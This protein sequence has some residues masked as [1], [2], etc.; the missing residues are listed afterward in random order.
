MRTN[1][2]RQ[3]MKRDIRTYRI[4]WRHLTMTT[5]TSSSYERARARKRVE[6]NRRRYFGRRSSNGGGGSC[7][8]SEEEERGE[9][10]ARDCRKDGGKEYRRAS[11]GERRRSSSRDKSKRRK[12]SPSPSRPERK[13][14]RC[15]SDSDSPHSHSRNKTSHFHGHSQCKY[16]SF[17]KRHW[18]RSGG[19]RHNKC[20]CFSYY[21]SERENRVCSK[22]K[23]R[24]SIS[25]VRSEGVRHHHS[26][27]RESVFH[28]SNSKS[29]RTSKVRTQTS[30][31]VNYYLEDAYL[32]ADSDSPRK[33]SYLGNSAL[34]G[35]LLSKE[36]AQM[37]RTTKSWD[38]RCR[39]NPALSL[40]Q[41][42]SDLKE[43]HKSSVGLTDEL[44]DRHG[45]W[46][47]P[48]P[49]AY[50]KKDQLLTPG[51]FATDENDWLDLSLKAPAKP[52]PKIEGISREDLSLCFNSSVMPAPTVA[53]ALKDAE[54]EGHSDVKAMLTSS[55][56]EGFEAS[57]RSTSSFCSVQADVPML[58]MS[59]RR[60]L[61]D[62]DRSGDTT[63]QVDATFSLNNTKIPPPLH[64]DRI[65]NTFV[66]PLESGSRT[67]EERCLD[68]LN[69]LISLSRGDEETVVSVD[70]NN[71]VSGSFTE[72]LAV[73]ASDNHE[74]HTDKI[75]N[76]STG[77]GMCVSVIEI[78]NSTS[79]EQIDVER[80]EPSGYK[81]VNSIDCFTSV[82]EKEEVLVKQ[83]MPAASIEPYPQSQSPSP[84]KS[85]KTSL[86]LPL[87]H[88]VVE[89]SDST[90]NLE[91]DEEREIEVQ[92]Q[93]ASSLPV[94][95]LNEF[96]GS[97]DQCLSP[98]LRDLSPVQ[99]VS[100]HRTSV[101][102]FSNAAAEGTDKDRILDLSDLDHATDLFIEKVHSLFIHGRPHSPSM[103]ASFNHC[104]S[105]KKSICQQPENK[106]K[107]LTDEC[108]VSRPKTL[109]IV[110]LSESSPSSS[111]SSES[112]SDIEVAL[113]TKRA[114]FIPE[115]KFKSLERDGNTHDSA[116]IAHDH[117]IQYLNEDVV[118]CST[119][120]PLR[121]GK[122]SYGGD[123]PS[124]V[125]YIRDK[126]GNLIQVVEVGDSDND[127]D[128][129]EPDTKSCA[130][131]KNDES[132]S[133]H[134]E[135]L[136]VIQEIK[137]MLQ[138][139]AS[140]SDKSSEHD[141]LSGPNSHPVLKVRPSGRIQ[142][143]S[144]EPSQRIRSR[145]LVLEGSES[146]ESD[147]DTEATGRTSAVSSTGGFK[148][149]EKWKRGIVCDLCSGGPSLALGEWYCW[150]CGTPATKCQC[151]EDKKVRKQLSLGYRKGQKQKKRGRQILD[152]Q[153]SGKVHRMCA[154]WSSE[155]YVK[156][157]PK[158]EPHFAQLDT[159]V[160]RGNTLVCKHPDCK[161]TGA[162]LGCRVRACRRSFH[163]P[164]AE[165]LANQCMVRMWD[166]ALVPVACQYHRHIEEQAERAK[167]KSL[168][169]KITDP[170]REGKM[171]VA[172]E[173]PYIGVKLLCEDIAEGQEQVQIPC[174]NDVDDDPAPIIR[175]ITKCW[176]KGR[177]VDHL[178]PVGTELA[179]GCYGC[180]GPN[181]DNPHSLMPPHVMGAD[182]A[183]RSRESDN[184]LDW[185]GERMYGR[186]PYNAAGLLQ[187]GPDSKD[188]IE[189][190]SRCKCGHKCKNRELQ[191]GLRCSLELFKT[192]D[193]GWGVRA[194]EQIPRGKFVVEYVGDVLTQAEADE[195]GEKYDQN[196]LSYLFNL[197]HPGVEHSDAI[198]LDGINMSNIAR[199]INHSCEGNLMIFRVFSET[200][201][202]RY[203]RIGMYAIQDI[204]VGD[205]LS[206][207]YN[208]ASSKDS[209]ELVD[210]PTAIRCFCGALS[211][212]KWLWQG[213]DSGLKH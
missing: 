104:P 27:S 158:K 137:E 95:Q 123:Q 8:S 124:R 51:I 26:R 180:Y 56:K 171:V 35:K 16:S 185:Q 42:D 165:K 212:R 166:G 177:P 28:G 76:V 117:S 7:S 30:C 139:S 46:L 142:I 62:V 176:F 162:T 107:S 140:Y 79:T 149:R 105:P 83:D 108:P 31:D 186:L 12:R 57:L 204:E 68:L 188:I 164:C 13:K 48:S 50:Y 67:K 101:P 59:G 118:C 15:R 128:C 159:A 14:I 40:Q 39:R 163:Y 145:K 194:L 34:I 55:Y 2:H 19:S 199:F 181:F 99:T 49:H 53:G 36:E 52:T 151:P 192:K 132:F 10:S 138:G 182:K 168:R 84:I 29:P 201:D 78:S 24:D 43:E 202:L 173:R 126:H 127:N 92:S 47:K 119:K 80:A 146:Q 207:D 184:R 152:Y 172:A 85:Q 183:N 134:P 113:R 190:N 4:V 96:S 22:R 32:R 144:R 208:Y 20:C 94:S 135:V 60:N 38:D 17:H 73:T 148:H 58:N 198:V 115:R 196:Q 112:D 9:S 116:D 45:D 82:K 110:E 141:D 161:K 136:P 64:R 70:T 1:D 90:T 213:A 41:P 156:S 147:E 98:D 103:P 203:F 100:S 175:Y 154:L 197:D 143:R 44:L 206:Y 109:E 193:R 91:D 11:H 71:T 167:E 89:L 169:S 200:T 195:R 160:K 174:T 150:C 74:Q 111:S 72:Q 211:C 209:S 69:Q 114:G 88:L 77:A 86:R 191:K 189:C 157:S 205:E 102:V 129:E 66:S 122:G 65:M 63:M 179:K 25:P 210:D 97:P 33:G 106:H 155:V 3:G 23:E 6:A 121:R 18:H 61:F 93:P 81:E 187:L 130:G 120:P 75:I 37:K 178:H 131:D 87:K 153:W 125:T 5:S 133:S 54:L 21:Y 170:V